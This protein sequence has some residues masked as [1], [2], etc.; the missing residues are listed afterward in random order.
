MDI[1]KLGFIVVQI[2]A[3]GTAH[4]SKSF[5]DISWRHLGD[6]GMVDHIL[7]IKA[8]AQKFA[9]FD[10]DHVGIFGASSGGENVVCALEE[11]NGFYKVGV[12]SSGCYDHSLTS[13]TDER[14]LGF[15]VDKTQLRPAIDDASKLEGNLLLI[16]PELDRTLDPASTMRLVA[17]LIKADKYF[18]MLVIPNADHGEDGGYGNRRRDEFLLRHLGGKN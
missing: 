14:W 9:S 16:A 11:S 3:M 5:H 8:A 15:P 18:E 13:W 6:S 2:D 12:A 10:L 4:R 7:W 1:A 17:S